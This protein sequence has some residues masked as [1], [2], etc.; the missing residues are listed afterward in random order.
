M[1][2]K[3]IKETDKAYFA[4]LFDGEGCITI[5]KDNRDRNYPLRV[6]FKITYKP[7]LYKMKE[8]FGGGDI[9]KYNIEKRKNEPAVIRGSESNIWNPEKWKQAYQYI[10]N[11][12]EAWIFLKIIEPY[13]EEKKEQVRTAIE[14]YNGIRNGRPN[15]ERCE[16]YYNKLYVLKHSEKDF[17]EEKNTLIDCQTKINLFTE[18]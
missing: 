13:C 15:I 5:S 4:G 7:I 12:K 9:N 11:S 1:K 3:E 8:L 6:M 18:V 10:L 17:N 14:Y 2:Y 16:Y